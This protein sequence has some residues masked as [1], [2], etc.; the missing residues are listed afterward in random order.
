MSATYYNRKGAGHSIRGA[1]ARDAGAMAWSKLPAQLR[2]GL[3]STEAA[4]LPISSEW[5]HAGKYASQVYVYY[6]GQVEAF[7]NTL[8][9]AGV[10]VADLQGDLPLPLHVLQARTAA[11]EAAEMI[12]C[13]ITDE[14][15]YG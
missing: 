14:E 12:R 3:T 6:I 4:A 10:T 9:A 7:W 8:D 5:H 11:R 13:E 1:A 2:R 15:Y